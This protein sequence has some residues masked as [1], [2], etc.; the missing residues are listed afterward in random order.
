MLD[1]KQKQTIN[2]NKF[3]LRRLRVNGCHGRGLSSATIL[4]EVGIFGPG[5]SDKIILCNDFPLSTHRAE[6]R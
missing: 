3:E 5:L 6:E 2:E 4:D 1:K